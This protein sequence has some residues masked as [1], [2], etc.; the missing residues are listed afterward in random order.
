MAKAYHE[1]YGVEPTVERQGSLE[2]L[3][4]KM[5]AVFA[6]SPQ[7]PF[8][9]MGMYYQYWMANGRTSL[10]ELDNE[11]WPSVK[12]INVEEFLKKYAKDTV[13]MSARF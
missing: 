1:A 9:W 6:A 13:G 10:G 4:T 12:P 2:E 8:A 7:N 5:S 3:F 11:R